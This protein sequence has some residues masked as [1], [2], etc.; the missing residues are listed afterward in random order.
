MSRT[1]SIVATIFS[2]SVA[3]LVATWKIS[4]I[5]SI[6]RSAAAEII[7][8]P[9]RCSTMAWRTYFVLHR[10][11]QV[12][13]L[14]RRCRGALGQVANFRGHDRKSLTVLARGRGKD[15]CIECEQIRLLGDVFDD[16]EN[17]ADGG[18]ALAETRDDRV[19]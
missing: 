1:R 3:W 13:D 6:I 8:E 15:R 7:D 16:I 5:M 10:A 4:W 9:E 17:L 19:R 2:L 18:G 12:R 14:A 11:D